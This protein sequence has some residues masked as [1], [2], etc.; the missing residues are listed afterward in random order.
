MTLPRILRPRV[1]R[2]CPLDWN[3]D[4]RTDSRCAVPAGVY[5]LLQNEDGT[6]ADVTA[7]AY[8]GTF[9]TYDCVSAWAGRRR[10]GWRPRSRRWRPRRC[11]CRAEKQRQRH[12]AACSSRSPARSTCARFAWADLD[13]DAD[14]DAVFVDASG[15][16]HVYT[17]RQAGAFVRVADLAGPT[18]RCV[19]SP[20]PTSMPMVRSTSSRSTRSGVVRTTSRPGETWTTREVAR[21]DGLAGA[22]PGSHRLIA[23]D[24]DNN[25][26][27]DLIASGGGAVADLA[28]RRRSPTAAVAA[29]RCRA[30]CSRSSISTRDGMLDLVGV[31]GG[32]PTRWLGKGTAGY[33]WK[34]IRPRAQ[35]NAGDQ[36]INSFGVG[37][38]IQ[39]R[40]GLL[41]QSQVLTGT[42]LHFRPRHAHHDRRRADRLA[43]R[44]RAG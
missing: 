29:R 25:G 28:R 8:T 14:P 4:F 38:D 37:G 41:V 18:Q 35:Q 13:R 43:E 27:L 20:S 33:H 17:N 24:L 26:A 7:R 39:V 22:S 40:S 30:M 36:R 32:R 44:R 11:A 34:V 15:A 1:T 19:A 12:V 21:W 5:L 42:P 16:L 2:S 31:S 9:P 3:H 6:F 23:A 10:D